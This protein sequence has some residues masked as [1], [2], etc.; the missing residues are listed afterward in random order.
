[1]SEEDKQRS[2]IPQKEDPGFFHN[3]GIQFRLI[4]RLLGD[5]R[6][7]PLLKLLPIGSLIYLVFP[8]ILPGPIDDAA[9]LGIGVYLFLE[10]CPPELVEEH[11][12]ALLTEVDKPSSGSGKVVDAEDKNSKES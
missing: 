3:L 2:M 6:I 7:N 11:R 8:D 9:I 1:M 12:Q 4:L 5:S 10:L